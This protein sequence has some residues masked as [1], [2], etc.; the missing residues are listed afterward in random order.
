MEIVEFGVAYG[1]PGGAYFVIVLDE[2]SFSCT[3]SFTALTAPEI[4][5]ATMTAHCVYMHNLN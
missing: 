2:P 1:V 3:L 4:G 5:P